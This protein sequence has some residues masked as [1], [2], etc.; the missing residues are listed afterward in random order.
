MW[1]S[2]TRKL[3]ALQAYV[4]AMPRG[5][6]LASEYVYLILAWSPVWSGLGLDCSHCFQVQAVL[7]MSV[8]LITV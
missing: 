3:M 8:M 6:R 1:F 4:S 7:D 2:S 5:Q